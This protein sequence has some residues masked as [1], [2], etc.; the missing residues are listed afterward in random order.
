MTMSLGQR[1]AEIMGQTANLNTR[2]IV[3]RSGYR[4]RGYYPSRRFGRMP[5]ESAIERH[6]LERL[7]QSWLT[8]AAEVQAIKLR[9]PTVADERGF[10]RVHARRA[11]AG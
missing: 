1:L 10:F 4:V 5:W 7:D 9:V 6:M 11:G 8:V 2:N 3:T